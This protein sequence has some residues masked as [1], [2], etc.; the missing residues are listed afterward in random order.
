MNHENRALIADTTPTGEE[1]LQPGFLDPTRPY[2]EL[3]YGVEN[4]L[5]FFRVDFVH[6]LSYLDEEKTPSIRKFAVLVSFQ[7]TL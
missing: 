4:I 3:G 5:K 7:F 1:A 2:I 6:R